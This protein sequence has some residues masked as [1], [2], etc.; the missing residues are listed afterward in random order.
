MDLSSLLRRL[1]CLATLSLSASR[2]TA[3]S[4]PLHPAL[5][6]QWGTTQIWETETEARLFTGRNYVCHWEIAS[7]LM[8]NEEETEIFAWVSWGKET[9]KWKLLNYFVEQF[10]TLCQLWNDVKIALSVENITRLTTFGWETDWRIFTS[11]QRN[12]CNCLAAGSHVDENECES[13]WGSR[14]LKPLL[15]VY[16]LVKSSEKLSMLLMNTET[17]FLRQSIWLMRVLTNCWMV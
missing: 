13:G 15:T 7:Y 5:A 16:L 6:L 1:R 14:I 9:I 12:R 17:F 8:P 11:E 2:W 4:D 3:G 10:S